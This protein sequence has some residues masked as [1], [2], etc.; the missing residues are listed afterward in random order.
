[1]NA[2]LQTQIDVARQAAAQ[3][4]E[5]DN[6]RTLAESL[7]KLEKRARLEAQRE[8]AAA[9]VEAQATAARERLDALKPTT[10]AQRERLAAALDEITNVLAEINRTSG[11]VFAIGS[12]LAASC[13]EVEAIDSTLKGT[14]PIFWGG[15]FA[16][17]W[18]DVG[19]NDAELATIP[20]APPRWFEKLLFELHTNP[21]NPKRGARY[22]MR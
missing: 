12:Q 20:D 5:V 16:E 8:R 14:R 4:A 6:T 15:S 21:Y 19:G 9:T 22:F 11:E 13:G 3:I 18:A 2:D 17:K 10:R 7:P 1:M